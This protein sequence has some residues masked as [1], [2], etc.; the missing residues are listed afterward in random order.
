MSAR[1]AEFVVILATLYG[2]FGGAVALAFLI[3][4]VDRLDPAARG[5]FAFRAAIAPGAALLW[6]LVL[7]RW[8][9]AGAGERARR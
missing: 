5:A 6:P 2:A 7:W 9:R 1:V 3:F 4:G 8:S